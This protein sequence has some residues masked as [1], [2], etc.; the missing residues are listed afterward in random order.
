M[1]AGPRPSLT[2]SAGGRRH[3]CVKRP[4]AAKSGR[5]HRPLVSVFRIDQIDI[6]PRLSTIPAPAAIL[7][8]PA[9][10]SQTA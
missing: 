8:R 5:R 9:M 6:R 7:A 3:Q 1:S 4:V 10:P 2:S